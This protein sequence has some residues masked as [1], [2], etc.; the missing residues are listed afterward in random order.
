MLWTKK[1]Q[2]L[3]FKLNKSMKIKKHPPTKNDPA[4]VQANLELLLFDIY[5]CLSQLA[6]TSTNLTRQPSFLSNSKC[7]NNYQES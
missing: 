4:S 6:R 2:N 7:P 3:K 5:E 1:K